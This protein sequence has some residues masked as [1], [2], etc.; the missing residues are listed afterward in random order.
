LYYEQGDFDYAIYDYDQAIKLNPNFAEAY[1]NR[2]YAYSEKDDF[3]RAI[4]DYESVLRINPNDSWA[5][6]ALEYF[7][8][9]M[10]K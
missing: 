7:K 2:A 8:D 1:L 6:E 10:K 5:K 3:T 4:A 9:K